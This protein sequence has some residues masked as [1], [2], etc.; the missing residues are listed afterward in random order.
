MAEVTKPASKEVPKSEKS[1]KDL[2][3]E[4][5]RQKELDEKQAKDL[6][7]Q[8]KML[9]DLVEKF[10]KEFPD[11]NYLEKEQFLNSLVTKFRERLPLAK[12]ADM[13]RQELLS[14]LRKSKDFKREDE[15]ELVRELSKPV[16]S[17][18]AKYVT[19]K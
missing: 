6:E 18:D 17:K 10:H 19:V 13:T 4:E 3:P 11:A 1:D 2:T 5:K 8:N 15:D 9:D 12:G 16:E 14:T 7:Q